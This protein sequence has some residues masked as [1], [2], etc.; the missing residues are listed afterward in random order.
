MVTQHI[1]EELNLNHYGGA[2]RDEQG[3]LL[4]AHRPDVFLICPVRNATRQEQEFLDSYVTALEGEGLRVHYPPRDTHQED[5]LGGVRICTQ[6]SLANLA[7]S[8]TH[9]YHVPASTGSRFDSGVLFT[10][11]MEGGLLY[12]ANPRAVDQL[13]M[14]QHAQGVGKSFEM[15]MR[16]FDERSRATHPL[17]PSIEELQA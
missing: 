3:L 10:K 17:P 2:L 12:L 8:A 13:I 4:P 16:Y 9:V 7:A 6:N 15:V 14:E 1:L 5:P 11:L